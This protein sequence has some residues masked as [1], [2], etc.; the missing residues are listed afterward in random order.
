M[1][2]AVYQFA[3]VVRS[4]ERGSTGDRLGSSATNRVRHRG[5]DAG[6]FVLRWYENGQRRRWNLRTGKTLV[7]ITEL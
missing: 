7:A 4:E 5:K 2:I 6:S 1:R 3:F